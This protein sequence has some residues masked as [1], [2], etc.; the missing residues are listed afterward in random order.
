MSSETVEI[1]SR[2]NELLQAI[3][4]EQQNEDNKKI[5]EDVKKYLLNHCNHQIIQDYVDVD[6]EHSMV[7][8]YCEHCKQTFSGLNG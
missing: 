5:R 1:M 2:V 7:V 6:V 4:P 8:Y 3:P